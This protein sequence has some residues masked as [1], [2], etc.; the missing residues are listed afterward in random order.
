VDMHLLSLTVPGVQ[1][2]A[3]GKRGR[4][5]APVQ[6]SPERGCAA[7]PDPVRG[8]RELCA[9]GSRG[10]CEGD[11]TRDQLAEVQRFPRELAHPERLSR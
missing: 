4:L 3:P 7:T 6:R 10:R 1:M 11:G 5:R 9:T 8:P 2:F